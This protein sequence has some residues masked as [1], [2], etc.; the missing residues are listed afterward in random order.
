MNTLKKCL[1][2]LIQFIKL[3]GNY[4]GAVITVIQDFTTSINDINNKML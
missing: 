2:A 1:R 3:P 4:K